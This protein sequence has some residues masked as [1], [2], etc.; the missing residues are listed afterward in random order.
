[1][2]IIN[3]NDATALI[4]E[5]A[6]DQIIQDTAKSSVV[7]STG[8][9]VNATTAQ[10]RVPVMES[11]PTAYFLDGDTDTKPQTNAAWKNTFVNISELAVIVPV[12]EAVLADAGFDI[13][14]EIQPHLS[15]A[16]GRALDAAVIF[17][18]NKPGVWGDSVVAGATAAGN[19]VAAGS[20]VDLAEDISN[21]M[22]LVEAQG[23]TVNGHLA[24]V[25]IKAELRNLRDVNNNPIYS[26]VAAAQGSTVYG[27]PIVFHDNGAFDA[28]QAKVITGDWSKIAVA[29]RQDLTFKVLTEATVGD[30]NL[31]E[32][33]MVA[34]RAVMRVGF[35][36]PVSAS[37]ITGDDNRYPFAVVTPAGS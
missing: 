1:M 27:S 19:V 33:D 9:R 18:A 12:P 31:A 21:A 15:T 34:L 20:G 25:T 5:V 32:Q 11:L 30:Y 10:T 16:F 26:E 37:H 14:G 22:G 17:G 8:T 36:V 23:Y 13:F 24:P 35:A 29:V 28:S 3:R 2:A 4:P 6:T 7:L